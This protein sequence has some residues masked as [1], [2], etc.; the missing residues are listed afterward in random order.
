VVA[1]SNPV[2]PTINLVG[3][4]VMDL[5]QAT[6]AMALLMKNEADFHKE[7]LSDTVMQGEEDHGKVKELYRQYQWLKSYT[8]EFGNELAANPHFF[9]VMESWVVYLKGKDS[10]DKERIKVAVEKDD[11]DELI[12]QTGGLAS[13]IKNYLKE[14]GY[15]ICDI[16][17]GE[18]GWDI[19]V[20][21]SEKKSRDLCVEI[22]QRYYRTIEIGLLS[23]SRRFSGHCLP[24]LYNWDDAERVLLMYGDDA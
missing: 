15:Q 7:F 9:D 12:E 14:Q 23:L 1:G 2:A 13:S 5:Q 4:I 24:G 22:H 3:A 6:R 11:V 19:G 16:S 10:V 8:R 18:D 21:C 17:A 20:R